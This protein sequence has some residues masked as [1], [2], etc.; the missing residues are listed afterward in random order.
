MA[1]QPTISTHVLDAQHGLPLAGVD[2]V[3][4]RV[5]AGRARVVGGGTTDG[6]GRVRRLL[7]HTLTA[8][9]YR[10]EFRLGRGF[11]EA[12]ALTIK[13]DDASRSWHVPLLLA[14]YS[15]TTYRGS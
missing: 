11:F 5:E 3:V 1:E 15:L 2:V 14:P 4:E 13:V 6:D 12:V 7:D 9:T 10:L 8:G